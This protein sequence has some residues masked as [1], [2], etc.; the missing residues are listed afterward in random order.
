MVNNPGYDNME[1]LEQN[2]DFSWLGEVYEYYSHKTEW[3]QKREEE[4]KAEALRAQQKRE[5]VRKA[6]PQAT[7]ASAES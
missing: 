1:Q 3:D 4:R 5:E 7:T 2:V 6:G